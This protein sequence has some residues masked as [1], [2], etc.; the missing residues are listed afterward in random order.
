MLYKYQGD[1]AK[2]I[3]HRYAVR[4]C[5]TARLGDALRAVW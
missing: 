3:W 4:A 2:S 1:E 5:I